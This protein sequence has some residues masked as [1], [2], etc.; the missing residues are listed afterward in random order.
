MHI[1]NKINFLTSQDLGEKI[2]IDYIALI[3]GSLFFSAP[4][5]L[6]FN[7]LEYKYRITKGLI[8]IGF[9]LPHT[10]YDEIVE[11]EAYFPNFTPIIT[12]IFGA[13]LLFWLINL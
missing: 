4:F 5:L 3:Y 9:P 2:H 8:F 6:I 10:I 1:I 13:F 12:L 11:E 7:F